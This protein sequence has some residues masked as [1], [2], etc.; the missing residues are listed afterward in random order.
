VAVGRWPKTKVP[1]PAHGQPRGDDWTR[2]AAS[3]GDGGRTGM[4]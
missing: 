1:A 3:G 2:P 4:K